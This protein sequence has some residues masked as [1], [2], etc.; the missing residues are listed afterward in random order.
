MS[1]SAIGRVLTGSAGHWE[2]ALLDMTLKDT[3][4]L[5]PVM[6]DQTPARLRIVSWNI[7]R[8]SDAWEMLLRPEASIDL[9]LLQEAIPPRSSLDVQTVPSHED[10]WITAGGHREFCT[11]VARLSSRVRMTPVGSSPVPDVGKVCVSRLGT[12]SA[13]EIEIDGEAPITAI[14]LYGAWERSREGDWIFADASAHRLISDL[15]YFI[16]AQRGHRIIA[17]GDLN[18]LYQYGE[19]RSRYWKQ[20]YATVFS[21][22]EALGVPFIGPQYPGGEQ[23]APWPSELPEESKNVPTFR[24]RRGDPGSATRQ[25]DFVFASN[26][27]RD[28]LHVTA[29]NSVEQWGPSDHCRVLIELR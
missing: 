8:C 16:S 6:L 22:M 23:A 28:R 5:V 12:L 21:R 27:L 15:S 4:D 25:L 1:T 13:A 9:A 17:A 10:S 20:R 7:A 11:A 2:L 24:V 19:N 14:S 18:I 26:E 3:Y 29:L